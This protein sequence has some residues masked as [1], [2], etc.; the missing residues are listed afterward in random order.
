MFLIVG[1]T[2]NSA[3]Y[4]LN[5]LKDIYHRDNIFTMEELLVKLN[6][7]NKVTVHL[8]S[9]DDVFGYDT[10]FKTFYRDYKRKVKRNHICS[11]THKESR[12]RNQYEA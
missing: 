1:H 2:K 7:S 12:Y 4:L 9:N 6:S 5:C 3:N 8:A 11:V 10:F